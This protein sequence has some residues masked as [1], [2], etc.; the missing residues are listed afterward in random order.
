MQVNIYEQFTDIRER[1]TRLEQRQVV[2]HTAEPKV[3]QNYQREARRAWTSFERD[4]ILND[5][6]DLAAKRA[7]QFGRSANS[8]MWEIYRVVQEVKT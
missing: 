1:L 6:R 2:N 5:I 3:N 8:I 4:V 7:T